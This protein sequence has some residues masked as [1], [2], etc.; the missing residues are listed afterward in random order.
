M[1]ELS[2]VDVAVRLP[3]GAL[4]YLLTEVSLTLGERRIAVIGP[5]GSGKSTL[6]R[7]LNGLVVPSRGTVTVDGLDTRRDGGKVRRAV[8]FVFADP[9]A[10]L[11]MATPVEDLELSLRKVVKDRTAR[12]AKALEILDGHGLSHLATQSIYDLSGGERQMVAMAAV[13]A[14]EP[15]VLVADEPTTLLDLRNG[16][17]FV[18]QLFALPQQVVYATHDLALAERADR[19]LYVDQGRVKADGDPR[20]V[21]AAYRREHGE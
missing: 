21:V 19:C 8:G 18:R 2:G 7:L 17:A 1:I 9:L 3:D 6:L 4:R 16:T 13:L 20:E 10:Q 11:V 12:R 5:N 15:S 14:V